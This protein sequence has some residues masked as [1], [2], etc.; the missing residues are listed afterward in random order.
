VSYVVVGD[1][2]ASLEQYARFA[3]ALADPSPPGLILHAAGPTDEGLRVVGVWQS[4][5]AWLEFAER[6]GSDSWEPRHALRA[7][8]P[9][10]LVVGRGGP[11]TEEAARS[12]AGAATAVPG[13]ADG[14]T[15]AGNRLE[16]RRR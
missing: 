4:E 6:L 7:L 2:A 13:S 9:E 15:S 16:G 12:R 1:V 10:H 3:A 8:L 5:E 11:P 14:V